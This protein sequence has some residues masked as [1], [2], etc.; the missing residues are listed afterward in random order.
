MAP[1]L[2]AVTAFLERKPKADASPLL[3]R[4]GWHSDKRRLAR[5]HAATALPSC[6][7]VSMMLREG[8]CRRLSLSAT[9]CGYVPTAQSLSWPNRGQIC[10]FVKRGA[11]KCEGMR[12]TRD[13]CI[14][15]FE[16]S[17]HPFIPH[18]YDIVKC[19]RHECVSIDSRFTFPTF[20]R[21][22]AQKQTI[23]SFS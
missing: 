14:R 8:H 15:R 3:C 19:Q 5:I 6:R 4:A 18:T 10:N 13:S 2:L 12:V 20:R 7:G 21:K 16:V 1:H 23:S 11:D 22:S 9:G 17:S